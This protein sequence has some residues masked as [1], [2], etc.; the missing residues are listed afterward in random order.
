MRRQSGGPP[1]PERG[2]REDDFHT[3]VSLAPAV[4]RRVA[5]GTFQ[6]KSPLTGCSGTSAGASHS[7]QLHK[8]WK[9]SPAT[10]RHLPHETS[11][12]HPRAARASPNAVER[13][14]RPVEPR[15]LIFLISGG[16]LTAI[17]PLTRLAR[18]IA[19][20]VF[21]SRPSQTSFKGVRLSVDDCL[22]GVHSRGANGKDVQ[23]T[24][25]SCVSVRTDA[26]SRTVAPFPEQVRPRVADST[27][28]TDVISINGAQTISAVVPSS[29]NDQIIRR[30]LTR[31]RNRR[32]YAGHAP[33]LRHEVIARLRGCRG[34]KRD[35]K[36]DQ[37]SGADPRFLRFASR[38]LHS[39][40]AAAGERKKGQLNLPAS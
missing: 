11:P 25:A 5:Q 28:R 21:G 37:R 15:G 4:L 34:G 1:G 33:I 30:P 39:R 8:R 9:N 2:A 19:E 24:T 31:T 32:G 14:L 22:N 7:T 35:E 26:G 20:Y 27:M 16:H 29:T 3:I 17:S 12:P 6:A 23:T 18:W 13:R 36:C 38:S 10:V 40:I